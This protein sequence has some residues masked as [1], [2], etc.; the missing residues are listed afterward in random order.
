VSAPHLLRL[1]AD[2][3]F[4]GR[5]WLQWTVDHEDGHTFVTQRATVALRGLLG[6][7]YWYALLPIHRWFFARTLR[8]IRRQAA[9]TE[10]RLS[11]EA[12]DTVPP[13]S[14]KGVLG[15]VFEFFLRRPRLATLIEFQ[16]QE[17]RENY[18]VRIMQRLGIDVSSYSVLNLHRIGVDAPVQTVFE[19]VLRWSGHSSCWPNHIAR[20][21]LPDGGVERI[22]IRPLGLRR[23][24]FGSG[25]S[26][27]LNL[28]PLFVLNAREIRH[29]PDQLGSDNARFLLHSCS[30]GYP[31][32]IFAIYV[33]S[34]VTEQGET[35]RTQ[36]FFCVG[37][38]F[39]G[40]EGLS[41]SRTLMR[42]WESVHNRV[43]ANVLNRF[44]QVC[45]WRFQ[46][47]QRG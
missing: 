23:I 8:A 9:G 12:G 42:G 29:S 44:K 2:V 40:K 35:E 18:S 46:R 21:E 41:R 31:I 16:T 6:T 45:E 4:P 47:M 1:Y 26:I 5:T 13:T 14:P 32:G 38:D 17:D 20:V 34:P 39:Y 15:D 11:A 10:R 30:G 25:T 19:E 28:P 33:R 3:R 27:G 36:V 7:M 43:S 24:P 22:E 37:F